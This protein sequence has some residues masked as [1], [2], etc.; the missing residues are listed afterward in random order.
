VG[1]AKVLSVVPDE[2]KNHARQFIEVREYG[3]TILFAVIN[4]VLVL[5]LRGKRVD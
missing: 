1:G 2:E 3:M 5:W 4:Q